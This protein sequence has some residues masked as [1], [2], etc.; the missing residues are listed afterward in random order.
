VLLSWELAEVGENRAEI[1][2]NIRRRRF[3][4]PAAVGAPDSTGRG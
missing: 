2:N 4:R 1:L 3:F